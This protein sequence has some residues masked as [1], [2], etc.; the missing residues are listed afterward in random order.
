MHKLIVEVGYQYSPLEFTQGAF[1][2]LFIG[3]C[4]KLNIYKYTGKGFV[5]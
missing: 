4:L 1:F 3:T 5:K 2:T